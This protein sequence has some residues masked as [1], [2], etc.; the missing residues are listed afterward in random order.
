MRPKS[1]VIF[2]WLFL[3]SLILS[4]ISSALSYSAVTSRFRSDP[5]LAPLASAGGPFLIG[6]VV[7]GL[8]V[9]LLLWFFISRRASN[10]AKW[11]LFAF[12]ALGVLSV[13]RN[14]QEPMFAGGV[15]ALMI[16]LAIL[17]VVTVFFLFR[18]DAVAWLEGKAPVDPDVF[19]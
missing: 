7:I 15:T 2:D 13:V 11:I 19:K 16:A 4:M 18:P 3:V 17:Q 9:S 1:I 14:L 12:T 8:G 5:T 6:S 10:V